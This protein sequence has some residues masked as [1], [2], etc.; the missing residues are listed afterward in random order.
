MIIK[1]ISIKNFRSYGQEGFT[2]SLADKTNTLI[3]EN[4]VGKTTIIEAVKKILSHEQGWEKEEYHARDTTQEIQI[5]IE[6]ILDDDQIQ[7]IIEILDL[8]YNIQFFKD[9]FAKSLI[10]CFHVKM[11]SSVM[12]INLGPLNIEGRLGFVGKRITNEEIHTHSRWQEI[13]EW[14][15][16]HKDILPKKAIED[17]ISEFKKLHK[18]QF[19]S[20]Y[21]PRIIG[22]SF[23]NDEAGKI[24][25]VLKEKIVILEEFRERSQSTLSELSASPNGR[26]LVSVLFHLKNGEIGDRKKYAEIQ[27]KFHDIFPHLEIDTIERQGKYSIEIQKNHIAS[28]T[29]YIGSGIIQTIFLLSHAIAHPEKIFVIDTPEVQLH[30]HIQRMIGK[31]LQSSQGS[32]IILITHSQYFLPVSSKS[33]IIRVIQENGITK[34]IYPKEDYFSE[35]DFDI[36]DQILTI[37]NKEFF[38]SRFVLLVEGLSDQWVM[39]EFASAEGFDLDEHGISVVPVN[40]KSNFVRYPKILEGYEIPWMIMADTDKKREI[41]GI[42][43]EVKKQFPKAETHLLSEEIEYILDKKRIIDG[44]KLFGEGSNSKNKPLVARYAAKKMLEEKLPIPNEIQ[45]VII[46]LKKRV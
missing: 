25:S 18:E 13:L 34:A 26:D 16:K 10:Y 29:L 33:R 19:S 36:Y 44:K 39:Q 45:K 23:D 37:D 8:P 41:I 31:L 5:S 11:G 22:F 9:F 3:G 38:F 24:V 6:C 2:F 32:Q 12:E 46:A 43:Q 20:Q 15:K 1:N 21:A 17:A 40:G 35:S 42:L 30:P 27:K 7:K 14:I 4:N 28:T